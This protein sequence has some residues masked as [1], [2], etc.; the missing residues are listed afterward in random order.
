MQEGD[1][2][3]NILL[4]GYDMDAPWLIDELKQVIRPEQRVAVVALSFRD[5]RV[6]S[7]EEWELLY[8]A[9]RGKYYG[10]ITGGFKSYGISEQNVSFI[11]YFSDNHETAAQKIRQADIVYFLGGL[12]DRMFARIHEL[13]LYDELM[14]HKGIVMGYSAGAVIQSSEYYL[15]PDDDYHEFSYYKGLPY[16][17]GFYIQVHYEGTP[18]QLAAINRVLS[19][20]GKPV[21]AL[22]HGH[23]GLMVKDG[24]VMTL[25][26]VTLFTP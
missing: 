6:H 13:G 9:E 25:G 1:D 8:S 11:N 26:E 2:L 16:L 15:A 19:E 20:R 3:I 23:G 18:V 22:A 17:N 12:P 24:Q 21:Y 14:C 5:N 7:L 10:G 4:E